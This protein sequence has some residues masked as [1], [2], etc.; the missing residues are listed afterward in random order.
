MSRIV[1]YRI[2]SISSTC[3]APKGYEIV[4]VLSWHDYD[5]IYYQCS[6]YYLKTDGK[7]EQ[8]NDGNVL[9]ENFWQGSKVYPIVYPIEVYSHY[10][11]KGNPNYLWFQ[12]KT[13]NKTYDTNTDKVTDDY[14]KWRKALWDCKKPIR[15]PNG[16]NRRTEC[17]FSLLVPGVSSDK[18]EIRL[19][20]IESRNR[21]Y[22]KEYKRLVRNLEV[23]KKLLT[24]LKCNPNLKICICEIDV[25][26]PSKKGNYKCNELFYECTLDN[27][28]V[29]KNDPSEA[30]GHGLCL[31]ESILEDLI[32]N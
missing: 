2:T 5:T 9:F 13:E 31:A 15:Y 3:I 14:F 30:F 7:E 21:I 11:R 28:N 16:M 25:P 20:Y 4:N 17:K 19:N 10:T 32:I 6:P 26:C 29:L 23:Y 8:Q 18:T 22:C 12:W 24:N 1:T 27:L